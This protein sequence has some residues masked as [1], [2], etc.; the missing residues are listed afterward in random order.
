MT[1]DTETSPACRNYGKA[2]S[3]FVAA[4][5]NQ[6]ALLPSEQWRWVHRSVARLYAVAVEYS[7]I[8]GM[9]ADWPSCMRR[10]PD[11]DNMLSRYRLDIEAAIQSLA[12]TE[13]RRQVD[14]AMRM[15]D[16]MPAYSASVP[17]LLNEMR[18]DLMDIHASVLMGFVWWQQEHA[19][20]QSR[21][22]ECWRD[23]FEAH[24]G[25][26]ALA[27]LKVAST[28]ASLSGSPWRR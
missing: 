18:C 15:P 22:C 21:A 11:M 28:L 13:P 7:L 4:C 2:V 3:D 20:H 10:W 25:V 12:G 19:D 8:E 24:W 16:Q 27:F 9:R 14:G 1:H 17:V 23:G 5:A 26:H 6:E